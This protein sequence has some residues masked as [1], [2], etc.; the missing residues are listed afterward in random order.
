MAASCICWRGG[1]NLIKNDIEIIKA[2]STCTVILNV[3]NLKAVSSPSAI[4][5]SKHWS[6]D[7]LLESIEPDLPIACF[8]C[9]PMWTTAELNIFIL[10][11]FQSIAKILLGL[12]LKCYSHL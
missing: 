12:V 10:S 6:V 4:M 11:S 1:E 5:M 9:E 3:I 7:A 8:K 2:F